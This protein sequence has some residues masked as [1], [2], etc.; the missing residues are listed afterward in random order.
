METNSLVAIFASPRHT[1]LGHAGTHTS[2]QSQHRSQGPVDNS[3]PAARHI[4]FPP[5][6]YRQAPRPASTSLRWPAGSCLRR[7]CAEALAPA[8]ARAAPVAMLHQCARVCIPGS[9]PPSL[10]PRHRQRWRVPLPTPDRAWPNPCPACRSEIPVIRFAGRRWFRGTRL[11]PFSYPAAS[12]RAST[13]SRCNRREDIGLPVSTASGVESLYLPGSG[14]SA[15][16]PISGQSHAVVEITRCRQ[17]GDAQYRPR[18]QTPTSRHLR[19]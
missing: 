2:R 9:A 13:K 19:L 12:R 7:R 6:Q 1:S 4:A 11:A 16:V 5:S 14:R 18:L 15:R 3:H 10:P 8:L 17:V